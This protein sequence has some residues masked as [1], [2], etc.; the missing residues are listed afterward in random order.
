MSKPAVINTWQSIALAAAGLCIVLAI[1]HLQPALAMNSPVD[2]DRPA[3]SKTLD[4]PMTKRQLITAVLQEMGIAKR[5]DQYLG[6]AVD[7]AVFPNQSTKFIDW[8]HSLL[9]ERAGWNTVA[10]SYGRRLDSQFSEAELTELLALAKNPTLQKLFQA[11]LD[12]Y[13]ATGR[14]RRQFFSRVWEDYQNGKIP[15]PNGLGAL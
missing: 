7:L 2:I 10:L 5:Y 1:A 9:A 3:A 15:M 6:N 14:D 8:L 13:G 11:E 12:S 4:Q